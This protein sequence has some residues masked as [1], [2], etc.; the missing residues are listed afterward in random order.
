MGCHTTRAATWR[1]PLWP[2]T[3][4]HCHAL[5][6]TSAPQLRRAQEAGAAAL[7]VSNQGSDGYF[8]M[9]GGASGLRIPLGGVPRSSGR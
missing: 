1:V 6:P 2:G 3:P 8:G 5:P 7:V 4:S 9:G